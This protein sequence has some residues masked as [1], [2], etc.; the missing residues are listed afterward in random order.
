MGSAV[1]HVLHEAFVWGA[2]A[3]AGFALFY[4]RDAQAAL[5]PARTARPIAARQGRAN[6]CFGERR[7]KAGQRAL[8]V[9]ALTFRPFMAD[10]GATLVVP[11]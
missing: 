3:L 11:T 8:R 5:A 9:R 7:L 4:F 2:V 6:S 10:T 1:K